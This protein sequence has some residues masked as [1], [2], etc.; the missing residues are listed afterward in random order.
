MGYCLFFIS[1]SH[2]T[3][4]C[5]LTQGLPGMAWETGLGVQQGRV[6]ARKGRSWSATI[7]PT[8]RPREA[9]T[10]PEAH[11]HGA[12][13]GVS[14]SQYNRCIVT[15]ARAWL[16]GDGSR[17]NQLY[18][19][20]RAAWPLRRVTIQSLVL[21]QEKGLTAGRVAIQCCDTAGLVLR[22]GRGACDTARAAQLA[23]WSGV[24]YDTAGSALRHAHD[25]VGGRPRYGQGETATLRLVT[26]DTA[27]H[28]LR[29]GP[30]H[31]L[32]GR[33]ERGLCAQPGFKVCTWCTQLVLN[34]VHCF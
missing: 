19:D 20:R 7:Q 28:R 22:Y 1:L 26:H 27:N 21:W 9:T 17:Y 11:S 31:G 10:Q 8:T 14:V 30:R 23:I 6:G 34:S 33:S 18:R 5:I 3:A 32:L 29:H 4:S 24:R 12:R 13:L 15:G 25:T 16:A 2:N